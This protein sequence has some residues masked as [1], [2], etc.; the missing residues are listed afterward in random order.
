MPVFSPEQQANLNN[1]GDHLSTELGRSSHK[2]SAVTERSQQNHFL[3]WA[4]K[5]I[6][7]SD[8]CMQ[9]AHPQAQNYLLAAYAVA[10]VTGKIIKGTMLRKKTIDRYI[11][12]VIKLM[13]KH[14]IINPVSQP[15]PTSFRYYWMRLG[16]TK[17]LRNAAT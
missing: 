6:G 17:K 8:P 14:G 1:Y 13:D 12:A 2:K 10:L 3:G 5:V 9:N 11:G 7:L 16:V 15:T 4:T